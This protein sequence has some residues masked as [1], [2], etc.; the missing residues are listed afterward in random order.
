MLGRVIINSLHE[1]L[2]TWKRF[3]VGRYMK[4]GR[5][6]VF[7]FA[8]D[9]LIPYLLIGFFDRVFDS[10]KCEG[11]LNYAFRVIFRTAEDDKCW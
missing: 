1:Q 7:N 4:S 8:K 9:S 10:F 6:R 11:K 2:E 3:F 5:H